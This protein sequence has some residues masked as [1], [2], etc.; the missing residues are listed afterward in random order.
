MTLPLTPFEAGDSAGVAAHLN[1]ELQAAGDAAAAAALVASSANASL[2]GQGIVAGLV[3]SPGT[4][5][6]AHVSAAGAGVDEFMLAGIIGN[7]SAVGGYEVVPL[8]AGVAN[9]LYM[10]DAGTITAYV[11]AQSPDPTGTFF[12]GTATCDGA[13]CTAVDQSAAERVASMTGLQDD[14]ADL[15]EAVGNPYTNPVALSTRVGT[16]EDSGGIGGAPVIPKLDA[17]V[18]SAGESDAQVAQRIADA[19]VA[20]HVAALHT[21]TG[22]PGAGLADPY[23]DVEEVNQ[24]KALLREIAQDNPLAGDTQLD[25]IIIVPG[26]YGDG[27]NGTVDYWDRTNSTYPL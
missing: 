23:P 9:Y 19:D 4:G 21:G 15:Q 1:T 11:T 20:A 14:V 12:L 7:L 17:L 16:L 24:A 22:E 6:T 26:V 10:D 18:T 13:D 2:H 27:S 3:L 5:L 8:T 25:S